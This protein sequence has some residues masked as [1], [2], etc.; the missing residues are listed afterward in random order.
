MLSIQIKSVWLVSSNFNKKNE[1]ICT[2]KATYD[3]NWGN[4]CILAV[5]DLYQLLPIGQSHV[6]SST[7]SYYIMLCGPHGW[8]DMQLHELTQIIRQ[9]D[10]RMII[11]S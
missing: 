2:V 11:N 4:I 7:N 6:Y 10:I 5:V 8:E 3:D 9:R 1:T